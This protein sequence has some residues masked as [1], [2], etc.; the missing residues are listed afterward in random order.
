[1]FARDAQHSYENTMNTSIDW[2]I[3]NNHFVSNE[4]IQ[5]RHQRL[6]N[7]VIFEV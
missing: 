2:L 5:Q 1:M 3:T 7:E 4:D 6:K